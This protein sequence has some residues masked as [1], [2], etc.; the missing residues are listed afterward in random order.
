MRSPRNAHAVLVAREIAKGLTAHI[1][2]DS[3]GCWIDG[4]A[5]WDWWQQQPE[6][7]RPAPATDGPPVAVETDTGS[8][9]ISPRSGRL[10]RKYRVGRGL[11]FHIDF[12]ASTGG[13]WLDR[14]EYEAL[15]ARGMHDELHLICSSEYQSQLRAMETAHAREAIARR[16]LGDELYVELHSLVNRVSA[17]NMSGPV[18]AFLTERLSSQD[19][20]S[21]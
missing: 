2:P 3:G 4:K 17:T 9:L 11:D 7:P 18:L 13:F 6:F 20:T 21:A 8:A 16:T 10:M 14:G 19:D 15:R 12:D 5:Y 1:C